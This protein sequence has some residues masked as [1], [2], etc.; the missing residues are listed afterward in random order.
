MDVI[1]E[2]I[3]YLKS[4]MNVPVSSE[5]PATRPSR[6]VTVGRVG[7]SEV[8]LLANPRIDIDAWGTS[9]LD[10]ATLG[11]TV[12]TLMWGLA[13]SSGLISNISRSTFYRSDVDGIHRY[14]GT[15][16]LVRNV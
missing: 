13:H 1:A 5:V 12:K 6:F 10:A 8:E 14:T 11:E 2:I 3:T 16:E 15:Y 4:N 7:G 9:D